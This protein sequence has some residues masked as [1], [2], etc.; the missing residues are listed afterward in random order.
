MPGAAGGGDRKGNFNEGNLNKRDVL[1]KKNI[2]NVI[3]LKNP[4]MDHI[5]LILLS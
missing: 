1:R 2:R 4:V 5:F 3:V